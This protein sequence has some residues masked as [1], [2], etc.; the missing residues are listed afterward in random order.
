[1][2]DRSPSEIARETFKILAG[3]RLAPTP[4]NYQAHYHEVAG[5]LAPAYFPSEPLRQIAAVLPSRNPGQEKQLG[6]LTS[7]IGQRSWDK[8]EA[9][10]V[11]YASFAVSASA[12]APLGSAEPAEPEA[13]VTALQEQVARLIESAQPALGAD[14]ARFLSQ[15]A[16]MLR[17]LRHSHDVMAVKTALGNFAH[18]LSFAAE[19]QAEIKSSLLNLL[20]MVFENIGELCTEDRWLRGQIDALMNAS[21]PPL[22]LRRLDD[23]E[24]RLRDVIFKQTEAKGRASQAQAQMQQL[25]A[26]FVE[27][28]SQMSESSTVYHGKIENCARLIE[29]ATTIEELGPVLQDAITATRSMAHDMAHSRDELQTMRAKTEQAEE[30]IARLHNELD[31]ASAQARHDAL[32]GVLNRRGLDEA[33]AR[34]IA[35]ARRKGHALCVALLDL[36]NFKKFNDQLGHDA[37]DA[38]LQ[39]LADVARQSIRPQ[40]SL[41]RYG[42]EEFVI[43]LPDT[44]LEAAIA[45]LTRLQ[46]EL[47]TRY[48]LS[49]K[50]KL[51][52]TFSAGVAQMA[53]SEDMADAIKRAD[54]AMYLA[55]RTGKNRVLGA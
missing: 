3:K 46:R 19:D 23:V 9:A 5:T 14:D 13:Q 29:Q 48:F 6:L 42:G 36:D 26:T 27:R 15:A 12:F 11:G 44:G 52:I 49:G 18:R 33:M 8:V 51:L 16:E 22:N 7:A 54:G 10:L 55:K 45:I 50:D 43:V 21:T 47:T 24:R 39:H 37:G 1:M 17:M 25:L 53:D 2:P 28:L 20:H 32:T 4:E 40:D 38:A 34:E 35:T 31:R 41:A 30:Q